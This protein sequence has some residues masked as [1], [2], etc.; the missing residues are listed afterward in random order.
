MSEIEKMFA[1]SFMVETGCTMFDGEPMDI[2]SGDFGYNYLIKREV[3]FSSYRVDFLCSYESFFRLEYKA[4]SVIVECDSQE[5]HETTE[6]Q[7]RT[8]KKRERFLQSKGINILR[9]T[10]KEIME[11]PFL[12]SAEV[13]FFLIKNAKTNGKKYKIVEV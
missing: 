6:E 2:K 10:G 1:M 4:S 5:W 9:F 7:R 3:K 8:E 13:V 11:D 12:C